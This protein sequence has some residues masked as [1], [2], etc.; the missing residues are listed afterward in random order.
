MHHVIVHLTDVLVFYIRKFKVLHTAPVHGWNFSRDNFYFYSLPS[1]VVESGLDMSLI[2]DVNIL[3]A[4]DWLIWKDMPTTY[5]C[6][7]EGWIFFFFE[8]Q[9]CARA[10]SSILTRLSL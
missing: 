3:V 4:S 5:T 7:L 1:L 2:S 9:N 6:P 10:A 8:A